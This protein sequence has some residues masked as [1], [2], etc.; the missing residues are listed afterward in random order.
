MHQRVGTRTKSLQSALAKTDRGSVF[1]LPETMQ[2][3]SAMVFLGNSLESFFYIDA[4]FLLV[5]HLKF[6]KY[7]FHEPRKMYQSC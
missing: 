5:F 2:Y 7:A 4:N 6:S 1:S 3:P